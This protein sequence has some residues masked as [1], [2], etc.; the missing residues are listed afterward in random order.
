MI[1]VP[2][3]NHFK[4]LSG[5][6]VA[7]CMAMTSVLNAQ[8]APPSPRL[9]SKKTVQPESKTDP[10]PGSDQVDGNQDPDPKPDSK[11]PAK[12]QANEKKQDKKSSSDSSA[13]DNG[14]P[15]SKRDQDPEDKTPD[16]EPK[17]GKQKPADSDSKQDDQGEKKSDDKKA[18]DETEKEDKSKGIVQT[19]LDKLR[20][21][22]SLRDGE[23][24]SRYSKQNETFV[25]IF[26]PSVASVEAS[27]ITVVSGKRPIALGLVVD[28]DGLV[29]TKASELRGT[30]GC[31][32]PDGTIHE[33]RVFGIDPKTDLA[34]LKIDA[35][36]LN[37]AQWSDDPAPSTG[38]WVATPK[39]SDDDRPTI[40]IVSVDSR[41][42][43]PSR[44]FIGIEM[45]NL[46]DTPGVRVNKVISRSPADYAD[47]LINDVIVSIDQTAV[48][49][50]KSVEQALKQYNYNDQI[51]LGI[52]RGDEKIEI[53]LTLAERDKISPENQRSNMQNS[54]GSILSRRRKD[55]P[56]AF[57]HD[58]MLSSKTCGGPVVDLSGKVVGINIARAGR[59]SSLALP[60]SLVREKVELM[61]TGKLAPEVVNKAAIERIDRDLL[62]LDTKYS[63]L[64]EKKDVLERKYNLENA[65]KDELNKTIAE[66]RKRLKVIEERSSQRKEELS[67]LRKQIDGIEKNR[68][69]LE[70]DREQLR[71]GSR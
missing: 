35:E 5:L 30:V 36:H 27:T 1:E 60:A 20:S 64:P 4:V 29:L 16:Q 24:V 3:S 37:V 62:E 17:S 28:S 53:K 8:D 10:Q 46:L 11:T 32:L 40:G 41:K 45:V 7:A 52:L 9:D 54:M 57:Q 50:N 26:Q 68:Q 51:T 70:A 6:W 44:P 22:R 49:N 56:V 19:A 12:P 13:D 63:D 47:L 58:S 69:R 25:E 65:R 67:A 33:A 2:M 21:S 39:A 18:D 55:F 43:P 42:I 23:R 48:T 14:K 71:T 34:L 15:D 61:K 31:R 38:R 59:V 66:L